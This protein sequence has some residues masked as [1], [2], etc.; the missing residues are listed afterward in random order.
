MSNTN[1]TSTP[2]FTINGNWA[3]RSKLLKA[4]YSQLTD[5][6]LKF[7]LGKEDELIK[8]VESRLNKNR[9]QVIEIIQ[10]GE[11]AKL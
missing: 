2:A 8:R 7:E 11:P 6:D 1:S 3:I 9:S 10:K 4:E 5:E